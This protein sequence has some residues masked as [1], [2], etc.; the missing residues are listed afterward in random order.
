[1]K[2]KVIVLAISTLILTTLSLV[3]LSNNKINAEI[4]PIAF[5]KKNPY[6]I[7]SYPSSNTYDITVTELEV[8]IINGKKTSRL[9][10]ETQLPDGM[11]I[12]EKNKKVDI[13]ALSTINYPNGIHWHGLDIPNDQDGHSAQFTKNE[14]YNYSFT[15]T[16]TGTYWYH[17]HIRPIL[18][19]LNRGLYAPFI[20]KDTIDNKYAGDYVMMLDDW[21]LDTNG[22]INFNS[23]LAMMRVVG[24]VE[25]VNGKTGDEIYPI[26]LKKGEIVKLRFI[27]TS[28]AQRQSLEINQHEFRVTHLDGLPLTEA[29]TTNSITLAPGERIDVELKGKFD[30]GT[31]YIKN[32]RNLGITIPVIYEGIGEDMVSPFIP[33]SSHAFRNI[34]DK[35]PDFNLMLDSRMMNWTINGDS[36]PNIK[37]I[38][39]KANEVYK[40]RFTNNNTRMN[41]IEHPMHIHGKHFQVLSVNGKKLDREIWK[42]TI[43]VQPGEYLDIAISF[44]KVG[45]WPLHC[46]I[47]D[48]EDNGMLTILEV[49]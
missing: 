40:I 18:N 4:K 9:A 39:L 49:I 47:I 29:Y 13:S 17:P 46:H 33:S 5:D 1:M 30:K 34:D 27:N 3:F 36:Y 11:I 24:G 8:E 44:D 22:K 26:S 21:P 38:K 37:P 31:Y 15:P 6:N 42:D 19:T 20:I 28:T 12:V 45:A 14:L 48:H 10:Y 16:D 43:S 7:I 32:N 25:T 2:N 35:A 41:A 23:S